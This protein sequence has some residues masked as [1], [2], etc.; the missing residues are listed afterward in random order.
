M[1]ILNNYINFLFISSL[2][3]FLLQIIRDFATKRGVSI[4]KVY[5]TEDLVPLKNIW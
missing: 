1:F 3:V 4:E 2:K 5:E